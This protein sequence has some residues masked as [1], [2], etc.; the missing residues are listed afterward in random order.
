[1]VIYRDTSENLSLTLKLQNKGDYGI[2]PAF[3]ENGLPRKHE[4]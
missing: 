3:F 2:C 1:M 4:S